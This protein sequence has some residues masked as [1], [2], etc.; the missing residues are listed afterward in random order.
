MSQYIPVSAARAEN[1]VA[2]NPPKDI[3]A[4]KSGE[5]YTRTY[6]S[7]NYG[8]PQNP[9]YAEALFELQICKGVVKR[10]KKGALKLNL[11]VTDK[12]DLAGMTQIDRGIAMT[13]DKYKNKFSLFNF[14]PNSPG[15]LRGCFFYPRT[16]TGELIEGAFPIVS[17]KHNEK[18]KYSYCEMLKNSDGSYIVDDK[19]MPAYKEIPVDYKTLENKELMCGVV[20]NPRDLYRSSGTPLPQIF[21]RSCMIMSMSDKGEVEHTKSEIVRQFLMQ[22]PE[23][24]NTLADQISKMKVTQSENLFN[25]PTA[26]VPQSAPSLAPASQSAPTFTSAPPTQP[27]PSLSSAPQISQPVQN[28]AQGMT[29]A[30]NMTPAPAPAQISSSPLPQMPQVA[31][32]P[33]GTIDLNAFLNQQMGN[34]GL[35]VQRI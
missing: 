33:Q 32:T 22:N 17:L 4:P 12:A 15:D 6:L 1:I 34:G 26:S 27:A 19:G 29:P 11:T 28:Y 13:V 8:T 23:M 25:K 31:T 21:V 10:N 5:K 2:Q 35:I 14:N 18:S 7:Y 30:P 16:E 24:L 3:T 9:Y 20:I